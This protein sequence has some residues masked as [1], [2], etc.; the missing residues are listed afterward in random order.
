MFLTKEQL[1]ELTGRKR[2]SSQRKWLNDHCWRF[3][4]NAVGRIILLAAYVE[5]K[6][7]CGQQQEPEAYRP[8]FEALR[9]HI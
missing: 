8:N 3:E 2:T 5:A 6:L 9:K 7:G 1:V 4:V